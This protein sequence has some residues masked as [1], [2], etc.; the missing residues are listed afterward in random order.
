[1]GSFNEVTTSQY[2]GDKTTKVHVPKARY[3]RTIP[4]GEGE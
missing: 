1:M 4:T 2:S 3:D